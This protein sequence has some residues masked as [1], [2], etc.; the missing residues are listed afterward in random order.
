MGASTRPDAPVTSIS[1]TA[2][3]V[4]AFRAHET[5]RRDR[6][7][8]DPFAARLAGER[9][10]Q[11]ARRLPTR[12]AR[13]VMALRTR[14][15]DDLIARAVADD[16]VDLVVNLAAGLDSRPYRLDLPAA[17]RWVEVDF[18]AMLDHKAAALTGA[19]PRC[20]L[21]RVPLD[22][23]DVAARRALFARL[24][25]EAAHALVITEG[26][27]I[28][29]RDED[30]H[31]LAADLLAVPA[32]RQWAADVAAEEALAYMQRTYN[33]ALAAGDTRFQWALPAAGGWFEARGWRERAFHSY[34]AAG[35]AYGR[36][37]PYAWLLRLGM[38]L[39]PAGR[40]ARLARMSGVVHLVPSPSHPHSL[41]HSLPLP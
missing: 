7:I 16:G 4:A 18:P 21:E 40:R 34:E 23:A 30:V 5:A 2:L 24:G 13:E 15:L 9:G 1:D 26:L 38:R 36:D 17:L 27:L 3:W 39:A 10:E 22:L 37:M 25:A 11:L 31:A 32:F 6:I 28:Y 8:D 20:R 14:L 29:L 35:R 12:G 41:N 33:R 19:A